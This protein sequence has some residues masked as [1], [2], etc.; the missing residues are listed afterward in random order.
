MNVYDKDKLATLA[1][2]EGWLTPLADVHR[3]TFRPWQQI[4]F[5]GLRIYIV[6]MLVIMGWGFYHGLGHS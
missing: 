1:Y 5:W 3:V 4:V 2:E 6:V